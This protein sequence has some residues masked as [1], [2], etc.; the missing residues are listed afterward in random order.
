MQAPMRQRVLCLKR[1]AKLDPTQGGQLHGV[2]LVDL[3][4]LA[5]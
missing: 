3:A 2:V 4:M 1:R 5:L